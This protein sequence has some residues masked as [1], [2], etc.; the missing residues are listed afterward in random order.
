MFAF[1]QD[2]LDQVVHLWNTH[3]M[4]ADRTLARQKGRPVIFY[5]LPE[6]YGAEDKLADVN[7]QEVVRCQAECSPKRSYPCD[8]DVFDL[9]CILME[10]NGWV[11]PN[12]GYEAA[13]LYLL[14]KDTIQNNL[15]I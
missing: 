10:E 6:L 8:R 4:R 11:V 13:R 5:T 7:I 12:D 9:C 2:D 1:W 15:R 14:L 3:S